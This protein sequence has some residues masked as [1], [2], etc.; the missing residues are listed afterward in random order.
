[1]TVY[2]GARG[3]GGTQVLVD[4][5]ALEPRLDLVNH[6]PSGLEWGYGGSGPGQLALAILAHHAGDDYA[7]RHHQQF[8]WDMITPLQEASWQL[9]G[10][11]VKA[12]CQRLESAPGP[13]P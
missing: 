2:C 6:S 4:G 11:A 10:A 1:M 5:V 3:P 9:T 8:K 12:W 13:R 7:V